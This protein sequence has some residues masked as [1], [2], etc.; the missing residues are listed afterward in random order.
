MV[1]ACPGGFYYV[2]LLHSLSLAMLQVSRRIS[3][4]MT[5]ENLSKPCGFA[6]NRSNQY[7]FFSTLGKARHLSPYLPSVGVR[8]DLPPSRHG[9]DML[10]A[11]IPASAVVVSMPSS[12]ASLFWLRDDAILC[13]FSCLSCLPNGGG[14]GGG[15][16]PPH[17]SLSHI[18]QWHPSCRCGTVARSLARCRLYYSPRRRC[19][20]GRGGRRR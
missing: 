6:D 2:P 7:L 16:P 15:A 3:I 13:L 4:A 10:L 17:L 18:S 8:D 20:G 11:S 9:I 5:F 1:R 14:G 19:D 12:P